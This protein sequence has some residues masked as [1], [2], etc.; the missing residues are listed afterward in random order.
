M[1]IILHLAPRIINWSSTPAMTFYALP[2]S[3]VIANGFSWSILSCLIYL[4]IVIIVKELPE[5]TFRKIFAIVIAVAV[6]EVLASAGGVLAGVLGWLLRPEAEF[7][8][9][10]LPGLATIIRGWELPEIFVFIAQ[11]ITVFTIWY[12]G[13]VAILLSKLLNI[14]RATS[15]IVTVAAWVCRVLVLWGGTRA[16]T[17]LLL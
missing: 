5:F 10:P 2:L 1:D 14:S 4:L 11:R 12:V 7:Q 8:K 15:S 16:A 6:I 9:L 3:I 17:M 13:V